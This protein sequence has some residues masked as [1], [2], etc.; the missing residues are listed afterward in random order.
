MNQQEI[1]RFMTE[2]RAEFARIQ[3]LMKR[4]WGMAPTVELH[5]ESV[6]LVRADFKMKGFAHAGQKMYVRRS[7]SQGYRKPS[8]VARAI[9]AEITS[10]RNTCN[11]CGIKLP[12][13]WQR[14]H[15]AERI[16]GNVARKNQD[17]GLDNYYYGK[18]KLPLIPADPVERLLH[19]RWA[20]LIDRALVVARATWGDY[21][22]LIAE[23]TACKS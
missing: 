14:K 13:I 12:S 2:T 22:H 3:D 19:P 20:A 15:H 18:K 1:E 7:A 5:F 16:L 23:A 8:R 6:L 9:A 10:H 17:D 21:D 4:E 11:E